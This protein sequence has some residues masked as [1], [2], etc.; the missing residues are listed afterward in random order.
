LIDFVS[1]F[2]IYLGIF[3]GGLAGSYL[4]VILFHVNPFAAVSIICGAIGSILGLI[5]GY[6]AYQSLDY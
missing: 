4:P 1:K 3:I 5:I 6:K 2:Y